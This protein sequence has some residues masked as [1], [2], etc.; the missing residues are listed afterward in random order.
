MIF[1]HFNLLAS[2]TV[3]ANIAFPL[4][5]AGWSKGQDPEPGQRTAGPGR[6]GSPCPRLSVRA[7]RRAEARVAIARALPAPKGPAV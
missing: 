7:L 3:S 6:A 1:Q 2:R 5:L 4:E